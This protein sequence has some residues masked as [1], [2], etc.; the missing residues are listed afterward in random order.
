MAIFNFKKDDELGT[1]F[2]IDTRQ[3]FIRVKES[4][5]L[6]DARVGRLVALQ[7][8]VGEWLIGM[9]E[10]VVKRFFEGDEETAPETDDSSNDELS[11][12]ENL[13]RLIL[14]GTLRNKQGNRENYFTRSI[15]TI[16]DIDASCYPIEGEYLERFM[17]VIALEFKNNN[18]S[19]LVGRY[20]LDES[21][22]AYLDGDRFFQRHAA[23]LGSTGSGKSWTVAT[24]LERAS[25][26]S[27]V[28]IIVFD[29][30]GEYKSLQFAQQL[31][32]AGPDDLKNYEESIFYDE[33]ILFLPYWLLNAEEMQSM[34]ID[35]SEFSAH[36]QV[37]AFQDAVTEAKT[38]FLQE[39]GKFEIL[40][41]FTIDS[42][43][44]FSLD[45]VISQINELNEEMVQGTRGIKQGNFYGQFSRLLVRLRSKLSDKRY[46]FIFQAP[47]SWQ[48]YETLHQLAKKLLEPKNE[49]NNKGIKV[50][51]FSEVPSDIVPIIV[52]L[53]A[54]LVFQIQFWMDNKNRKPV[55]LVCD[56]AHLYLP[57]KEGVN[58]V[59]KRA[60]ENFERIAKEGRKYGVGLLVVS[61][62]PSDVSSTILCQCNNFIALRLTN[63]TDQAV[64]K[65]L[66]PDNLE[67]L[68][69]VL[70]IL[71]VGEAV[72]I[73]DAVLLPT[74]VKLLEPT[75]ENRPLS[76]T[77][78]FWTEWSQN[79]KSSDIVSA[80]ENMRK[81]SRR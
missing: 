49:G 47:H 35:R 67:P 52:G 8:G 81:Q 69:D 70:P 19:L 58:P 2:H 68:M 36:N 42:P 20:T 6:K 43:V 39:K 59:E 5:K 37:M 21:A 27:S 74:R 13:V 57:V 29:M 9:I 4:D 44:P 77:I 63:A 1:V 26:L 3:V 78:D 51:D 56:E 14:I 61:Q 72:I 80:V 64:V 46:G 7:G 62:R 73:G 17:G 34:F 30:H 40:D 45:K 48:D 55:V 31:K 79:S 53:V 76:A 60:L 25:Q 32:I 41:S 24:I 65:K 71:D 22:M 50:I 11:N 28:N 18:N 75:E 10:K 23:I 15:L 16:P 12:I 54:R 38:Q 66:M 33:S